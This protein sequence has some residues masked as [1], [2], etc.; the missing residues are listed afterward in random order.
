MDGLS[1]LFRRVDLGG[2]LTSLQAS[3]IWYRV[4][5]YADDPV[6]FLIPIETYI[7][8]TQAI[9]EFF[10]GVPELHTNLSKCQFTS[11]RCTEEQ[12]AQVMQW[13]PCQLIHL[14]CRYLGVPLSVYKLK[15]VYLL[16]LVDALA[17]RLLSWQSRF[18]SKADC[19]TLPKVTLSRIPIH[20]LIIRVVTLR[21]TENLIKVINK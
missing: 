17:D 9:M 8:L 10:A 19:I 3:T 21:V 15:K 7:R 13:F 16:H 4:Y 1:S 6:I 11:I 5:L 2:F 14:Q 12:I 20:V 18:M